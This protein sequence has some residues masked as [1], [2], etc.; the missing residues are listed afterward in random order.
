MHDLIQEFKQYLSIDQGKSKNTIE[1]YCRD[2]QKFMEYLMD[3]YTIQTVSSINELQIKD[4]LANIYNQGYT[5]STASRIISSLRQFFVF[6]IKN[7]KILQNPMQFIVTPKQTKKLPKVLNQHQIEQII[8]GPDIHTNIGIRDRS[9]LELMY[10]TGLR[11]SELTHLKIDEIHL[12][13]GFIQTIGKGNKERIVPMG[14]EAN[15]WLKKYLDDVRF[16]FLKRGNNPY[17]YLTQRGKEFTRQGIWKNIKKYTTIANINIDVSP[18]ML[19]HSF[20]T[21]ILE[22]GAD[23]RM[24]QELLGHADVSTTQIYTHISKQRLQEVYH[25]SFPRA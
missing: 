9:I 8:N 17:V 2:V 20:A 5:S 16:Q 23:L 19:R 25:K 11:V 12:E 24:V 13:L 14:D 18:H 7:K 15:Y 10:A 6:L 22:N 4:Y 1:S 21:H 3:N